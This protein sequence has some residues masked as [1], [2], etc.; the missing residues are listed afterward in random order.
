[1]PGRTIRSVIAESLSA[2]CPVICSDETPWTDLLEAGGGMVVRD[3]TPAGL[4]AYLQRLALMSTG[5]RVDAKIS[6]AD[7]YLTLRKQQLDENI[8][9]EVR[10]GP[11][12]P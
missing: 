6:A 9:D 8:L 1:M 5:E 4:A 11:A 12:R 7:V 10:L 3:L 2:S